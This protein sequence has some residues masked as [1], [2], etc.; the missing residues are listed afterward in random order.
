MAD[1]GGSIVCHFGNMSNEGSQISF[2]RLLA[3]VVPEKRLYFVPE[4]IV[5]PV[6]PFIFFQK[7]SCVDVNVSD[8]SSGED[9]LSF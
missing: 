4:F 1:I 5:F 8:T 3:Q 2:L 9:N 7:E 6:L